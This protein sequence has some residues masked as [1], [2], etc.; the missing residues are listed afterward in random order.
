M[1]FANPAGNAA[2][3]AAGYTRAILEVLGNRD[4]LTVAAEL[5]PWLERRTAELVRDPR[6]AVGHVLECQVRRVA[7]IRPGRQVPR[8]ALHRRQQGVDRHA[9]PAGVEL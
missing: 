1:T 9:F 3:A 6:P 2:A 4:P 7:A 5:I 8:L